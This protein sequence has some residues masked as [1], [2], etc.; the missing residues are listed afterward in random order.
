MTPHT[1]HVHVCVWGADTLTHS[2]IHYTSTQ[3]KTVR[4]TFG[5]CSD[6]NKTLDYL[7]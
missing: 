5:V 6:R 4:E 1:L 3:P 2:Y 7:L